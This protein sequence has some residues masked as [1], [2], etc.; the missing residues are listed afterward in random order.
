MFFYLF[1]LAAIIFN[2]GATGLNV[3]RALEKPV[4]G[5]R[6]AAAKHYALAAVFA[7]TTL[8]MMLAA[9]LA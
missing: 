1:I 6:K 9:L 5:N 2:I 8:L 4:L 7:L 3:Y